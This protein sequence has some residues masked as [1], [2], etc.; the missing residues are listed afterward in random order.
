MPEALRTCCTSFDSFFFR[1]K[2]RP[3]DSNC[4]HSGASGFICICGDQGE[5][6][7]L[8]HMVKTVFDVTLVF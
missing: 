6:F 1:W 4:F 2:E 7:R 5:R 3:A 8:H